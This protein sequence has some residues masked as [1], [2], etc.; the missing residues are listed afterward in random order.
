VWISSEA[1]CE[2]G[3]GGRLEETFAKPSDERTHLAARFLSQASAVRWA[4]VL[5][6]YHV[7]LE[8]GHSSFSTSARKL[9]GTPGARFR[10][11]CVDSE[12]SQEIVELE[13]F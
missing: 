5:T 10:P 11:V 8:F 13:A 3:R 2:I 4:N 9:F 6:Q 12:H 1:A 7:E